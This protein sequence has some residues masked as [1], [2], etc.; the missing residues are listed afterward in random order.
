M[1]FRVQPGELRKLAGQLDRA[2]GDIDSVKK[3]L[4]KMESF[5]GSEGEG[6]LNMTLD[7]HR[8]AYQTLSDWLDTLADTTLADTS[9]AVTGSADYY[10]RTDAAA[11]EELDRSYPETNVA[12]AR[13]QSSIPVSPGHGADRFDDV[14]HP[15]GR[16]TGPKD[17]RTELYGGLMSWWDGLSPMAW[18]GTIIESVSYVAVWLDW[19]DKP[20]RPQKEIAMNF[21]G[22]WAA[23][24]ASADVLRNVALAV[25][26]TSTNIR[27][28]ARGTEDV[29]QGNAGDGANVYLMNLAKPLDEARTP[30]DTLAKQYED[31]SKEMQNLRDSVVGVI[32]LMGDAALHATVAIKVAYSLKFTGIGVAFST[33]LVTYAGFHLRE[34]INGIVT[35]TDIISKLQTAT[36]ALKA[37]Q[38]GF[39][40]VGNLSLPT[41][42]NSPINVPGR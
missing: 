4:T 5:Q 26:D 6:L 20:Y 13:E 11:A 2:Q 10:E 34:L 22:D 18:A 28:A 36:N 3:H 35:A 41:L 12:E 33:L 30:I 40:S 42:P 7:S 29:W 31:T 25:Q 9:A 14:A 1:S 23:V 24:R 15:A 38:G 17:Y 39:A 32:D 8:A 37:A 16:L 27:S 19:L 21:L